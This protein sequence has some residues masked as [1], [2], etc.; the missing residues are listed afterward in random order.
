MRL[1]SL[2]LVMLIAAPMAYAPSRVAA[3]ALEDAALDGF[4]SRK[5]WDYATC[6]AAIVLASGTG[7]WIVAGIVC[8]KVITEHWTE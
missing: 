8:G 1:R 6:G 7:G 3:Q 2:W 5:F 4:G